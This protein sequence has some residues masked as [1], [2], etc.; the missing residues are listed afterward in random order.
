MSIVVSFLFGVF[1][2]MNLAELV[3]M[4]L[5]GEQFGLIFAIVKMIVLFLLLVFA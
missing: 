3:I 5:F 2:A 4:F 1:L